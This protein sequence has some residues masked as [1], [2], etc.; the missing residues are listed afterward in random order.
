MN[1]IA[2]GLLAASGIILTAVDLF[3]KE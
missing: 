2:L 3:M 1:L